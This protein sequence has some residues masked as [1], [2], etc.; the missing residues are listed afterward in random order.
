MRSRS[1]GAGGRRSIRLAALLLFL[2]AW[3]MAGAT[4]ASAHAQLV[5]SSPTSGAAFDSAPTELTLEFTESV[6]QVPGA[7]K[8]LAA[9]GSAAPIGP[10]TVDGHTLHVPIPGPLPDAGY[11]FVYRVISADSHPVAGAITFTIGETA[12][13]ASATTVADAVG[14]SGSTGVSVLAGVNRGLTEAPE[15]ATASI[16]PPGEREVIG[17][18]SEGDHRFQCCIHPW[19]RALIKVEAKHEE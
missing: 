9:D 17:S 19:M 14:G 3:L 18:L 15:C 12:T 16:I 8:L 10:T 11:V 2:A 6:T 5:S 1:G 7:M 13:A 4:P